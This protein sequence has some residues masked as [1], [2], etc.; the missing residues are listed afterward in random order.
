MFPLTLAESLVRGYGTSDKNFV[1]DSWRFDACEPLFQAT[2][3]KEQLL[4]MQSQQMQHRGMEIV[5]ADWILDYFVA[6]VVRPA[7]GGSALDAA[8][9][10][11]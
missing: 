2:A 5:D 4:M 10:H 3:G 11:P 8:P 6:E 7:V 1:H 9:R